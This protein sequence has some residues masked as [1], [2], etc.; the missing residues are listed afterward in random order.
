MHPKLASIEVKFLDHPEG[1]ALPVILES[2]SDWG[3]ADPHGPIDV[4][5]KEV[6]RMASI[7]VRIRPFEI[8]N[9]RASTMNP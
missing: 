4:T 6:R 1:K 9:C 2:G 8:L 7:T 3:N 5:P